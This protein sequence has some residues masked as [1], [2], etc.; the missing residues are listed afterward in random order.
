MR[1]ARAQQAL[2]T[3]SFRYLIVLY[4][5]LKLMLFFFGA[6]QRF[7][8][9]FPSQKTPA[10]RCMSQN[11]VPNLRYIFIPFY[12][13]NA[14]MGWNKTPTFPLPIVKG[15]WTNSCATKP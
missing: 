13:R 7:R 6:A 3:Y 2:G 11:C 10:P 9:S 15:T 4:Y 12:F 5:N 1:R 8:F 14:P